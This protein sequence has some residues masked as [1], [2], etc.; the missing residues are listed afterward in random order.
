MDD[1]LQ[2]AARKLLELKAQLPVS[3][4]AKADE[5]AD[6]I[7][8]CRTASPQEIWETLWDKP[9]HTN[10]DGDRA[11]KRTKWFAD[12]V[13]PDVW[14]AENLSGDYFVEQIPT[15]ERPMVP[16]KN[17][18]LRPLNWKLN[19]SYRTPGEMIKRLQSEGGIAYHLSNAIFS[20]GRHLR[21]VAASDGVYPFKYLHDLPLADAVDHLGKVLGDGWGHITTMH[22]LTDLGL[23]CK[24]DMHLVRTVDA[25]GLFP[26]KAKN[27]NRSEALEIN[28]RVRELLPLVSNGSATRRDL[29]HLDKVLMEISNSEILEETGR[30]KP[31]DDRALA[32][33]VER[34]PAKPAKLSSR[35][36]T[37][38]TPPQP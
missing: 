20:A 8:D 12:N 37:K 22:F 10:Q 27:V 16:D 1:E 35:K 25:I 13:P 34:Q 24:P 17:G 9:L 30:D 2:A 32:K 11:L 3:I 15:A 31:L 6:S 26:C 5:L 19:E 36:M 38:L 14:R 28:R 23:A 21:S 33:K 4:L 29:R 18:T 7:I